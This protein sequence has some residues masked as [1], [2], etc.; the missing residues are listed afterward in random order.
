[1]KR[2]AAK[3]DIDPLNKSAT[4][5]YDAAGRMDSTTDRLG[6]RRDRCQRAK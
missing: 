2:E 6:R 5:S 1:M 4:Y 3:L